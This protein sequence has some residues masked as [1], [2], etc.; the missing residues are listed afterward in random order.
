MK[1]QLAERV[2]T[3][4]GRRDGVEQR[5]CA[6]RWLVWSDVYV[7]EHIF[8]SFLAFF[9]FTFSLTNSVFISVGPERPTV[10]DLASGLLSRGGIEGL[11]AGGGS[12]DTTQARRAGEP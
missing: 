1:D 2:A 9:F 8:L 11:R 10:G 6:G 12:S 3:G 5:R 7:K 4:A